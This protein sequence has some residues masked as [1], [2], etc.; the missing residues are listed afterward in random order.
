MWK[1]ICFKNIKVPV[2]VGDIQKVE[3]NNYI[4]ISVFGD[5]NKKKYPIHV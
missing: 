2:K 1:K 4:S 3:E 5:K